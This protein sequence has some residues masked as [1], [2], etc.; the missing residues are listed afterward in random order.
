V[1]GKLSEIRPDSPEERYLYPG[2]IR[3]AVA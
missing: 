1:L 3:L 2:R